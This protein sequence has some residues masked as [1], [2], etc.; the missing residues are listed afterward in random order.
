MAGKRGRKPVGGLRIILRLTPQEVQV[1]D[2][3]HKQTGHSR[4]DLIRRAIDAFYFS[5][6]RESDWSPY[7][8]TSPYTKVSGDRPGDRPQ[9]P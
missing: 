7:V 1:L 6:R 5:K 4:T 9:R 2:E 3:K 8:K